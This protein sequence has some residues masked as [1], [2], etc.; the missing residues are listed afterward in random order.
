MDR[1]MKIKQ[2]L[3]ISTITV[4][5]TACGTSEVIKNANNNTY[6]VSAQYGALNG[7]WT[8][9]IQEATDKAVAFCGS[10]G[11]KYYFMSEQRTGVVGWSPQASNITF[12]CGADTV[13]IVKEL[14]TDCKTEMQNPDLD[15]IR[16]KIELYRNANDPAPTFDIV[17]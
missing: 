7:S 17:L 2:L 16:A 3:S 11:Q 13:A 10:M 14:Q 5:L 6:S 12:G 1:M 8:R 9:A 15:I 4:L